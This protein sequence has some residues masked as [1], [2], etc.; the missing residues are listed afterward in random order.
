MAVPRRR[1][2]FGSNVLGPSSLRAEKPRSPTNRVI[3]QWC[4]EYQKRIKDAQRDY[5]LLKEQEEPEEAPEGQ[6]EVD[7]LEPSTDLVHKQLSELAQQ[8]NHVIAACNEE[9]DL[10]KEDFDSVKNGIL[11][12]E[13]RLQT[14]KS[15]IDSEVQGVRSMMNFQQAI[16]EEVRSSVHVLQGQDN[17]IVG[18]ATEVF[19]GLRSELQAQSNR[20]TDMHLA[21]Y[22]QKVSV[23][24]LQKS[25]TTL[26][27]KVDKVTTVVAA[28]TESLKQVLT[29]QE[30][31]QHRSAM[32][33]TMNSIAE[34]NTGLTTAMDQYKFSDS[35]PREERQVFAGPSGTRATMHPQRARALESPSVSSLRDTGS[36]YSWGY[37]LRGGLGSNS[38]GDAPAGGAGSGAGDAPAGGIGGGGEPPS[39]PDPPPSDNGRGG[40]G[41]MSRRRRRIK[42]LEFAKPIKIKEP[43][44]FFGKAGEDFDTWW[45]LVQVYIRDQPE[46]FPEDE[47]TIDW[48]GSL[49][50]SYAASWHIQW[51][52]G[53]LAGLYP[54]SM[55]GYI[56]ALMLRFEDKDARDEAYCE[57]EKVRYEGCIR[58]MFTK[59]QTHNDKALVTGAALKKLILERL[60]AKILEQMHTVDLTGKTDQEIMSIVTNASRTAEKWE[61]ARSNLGLKAQF[62]TEEKTLEKFRK[63]KSDRRERRP[64]KDGRDRIGKRRSIRDR[65]ERRSNKDNKK[66]E[67]IESSEIERRKSAGEC[68]RCAWP[69]DRKGTHRVKDCVRPIKLDKGTA[70]YPKSKE[71][72]KM[73]VAAMQQE[74]SED[75]DSQTSE[76]DSD[77][78][79]DEDSQT[80]ESE[81]DTQASESGLEQEFLDNSERELEEQKESGNWWDSPESS[82]S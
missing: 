41:R 47:R 14:E 29:K 18:E 62:R 68:L 13:S 7:M 17:Q 56:N 60:P 75:E 78:S 65:S 3:P 16:L 48:I 11:I 8:I 31:R 37:G 70:S 9:K 10:L 12:M 49:M 74:E 19:D 73:K 40:A 25:T 52:K 22:A 81:G 23:Q 35:T 57:L 42:D 38:G 58:D 32:E 46:K 45:V 24:A 67:G 20:I 80:D 77:D 43:K 15:R 26:S 55:T 4:L 34:I 69:S 5:L 59:I 36:E 71:Y 63:D 44:M 54:K 66:T 28:I 79:G 39:P 76:S 61:A 51:L 2:T 6:G 53:T 21:N 82:D 64:K 72:Q 30:L 27:Q 1:L 50:D 33:E